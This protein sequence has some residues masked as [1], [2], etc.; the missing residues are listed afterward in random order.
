MAYEYTVW[1]KSTK[2]NQQVRQF[3]LSNLTN[4]KF[5]DQRTANLWANSFAEQLNKQEHL[6]ATDWQGAVKYQEVGIQ[7]LVNSMSSTL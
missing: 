2:L 5:N 6:G 4:Q 7:T 1:A 3:H